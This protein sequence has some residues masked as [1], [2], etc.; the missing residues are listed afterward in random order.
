MRPPY[1]NDFRYAPSFR[2]FKA[3]PE[4]PR[5]CRSF[6]GYGSRPDRLAGLPKCWLSEDPKLANSDC[7][8]GFY[9]K[10]DLESRTARS[11]GNLKY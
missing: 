9:L 6:L 11:V 2:S 1:G 8:T 3:I 7:G 5:S 10:T 4:A